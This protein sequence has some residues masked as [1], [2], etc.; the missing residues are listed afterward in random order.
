[1]AKVQLLRR[2]KLAPSP[3]VRAPIST[4]KPI[5]PVQDADQRS[6]SF[7]CGPA[8]GTRLTPDYV[9]EAVAQ[10]ADRV[11]GAGVA[12]G[13]SDDICAKVA[14]RLWLFVMSEELE[15][16]VLTAD[17]RGVVE[18]HIVKEGHA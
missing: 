3:A 7:P 13:I 5:A 2:V 11:F 4:L 6:L 18:A 17:H 12:T 16:L 8:P 10:N 1:M 9:R 14:T 15:K